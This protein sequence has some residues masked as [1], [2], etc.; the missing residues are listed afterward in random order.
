VIRWV[1]GVDLITSSIVSHSLSCKD[2]LIEYLCSF[3]FLHILCLRYGCTCG[4]ILIACI[5]YLYMRIRLTK[6]L[7]TYA[8]ADNGFMVCGHSIYLIYFYLYLINSPKRCRFRLCLLL[9][10]LLATF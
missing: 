5:R 8:D 2:C 10:F 9:I 1:F 4:Q 6:T 7:S 3:L